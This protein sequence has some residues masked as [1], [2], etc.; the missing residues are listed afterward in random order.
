M[1]FWNN[2]TVSDHHVEHARTTLDTA[3]ATA[4]SKATYTGAGMTIG[5]WLL[6][7]EFAVLFG[8]LLGLFGFF[9]NWYYKA[10]IAAAEIKRLQDANEREKA[11]H[12]A[13]ME[14]YK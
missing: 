12:L 8:M 11:E 4:A 13:R 9:V 14:K 6:S 3:V 1:S 2:I 5:G 10:K 7:S